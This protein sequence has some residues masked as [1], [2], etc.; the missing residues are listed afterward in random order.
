MALKRTAIIRKL[1][2]VAPALSVNQLIPLLSNFWFTGKL[3]MAFNDQIALAVPLVTTF[4]GA[5]SSKLLE[6]LKASH[7]DEIT[8]EKEGENLRVKG[9]DGGTNIKL[10]ML[11]PRF[12]FTMP[13][14]TI[15]TKSRDQWPTLRA[16]EHC[17]LSIGTDTSVIEQLGVT[18]EPDAAKGRIGFYATDDSTLTRA[19]VK[20]S[21]FP[22]KRAILP[23]LF[24]EQMLRLDGQS[25]KPP[26][27]FELSV[28]DTESGAKE[29]YALY[30]VGEIL[31]YGRLLE[32]RNPLNFEERIGYNL[33][34]QSAAVQS[35][36]EVPEAFHSALERASIV[37][38]AERR[39]TQIKVVPGKM[40]LSSESENEEVKD[41]LEDIPAAQKNVNISI[42]AKLLRRGRH[43][44]KINLTERCVILTDGARGKDKS[45]DKSKENDSAWLYLVACRT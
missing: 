2:N 21:E 14:A 5:V 13:E 20:A 39:P 38:D 28:R 7:A 18:L 23:R 27:A 3:M 41:V 45:K 37:C 29:R 12:I 19:Y 9:T 42:D 35:A 22:N 25:D 44:K 8:M 32:T 17:M 30:S 16:V 36:Y 6:L 40:T 43:F 11:E 26:F 15:K 34:N 4:K 31:L 33:P 24:C 10:K 1:E